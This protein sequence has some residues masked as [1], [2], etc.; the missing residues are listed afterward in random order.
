MW[1][2]SGASAS[3]AAIQT[4]VGS[5]DIQIQRT[6]ATS[7]FQLCGGIAS[8]ETL[9]RAHDE[10]AFEAAFEATFEA[11]LVLKPLIPHSIRSS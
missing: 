11:E 2:V 7:S 4:A 9:P 10:A 3:R 5:S 6:T 8:T 1:Q